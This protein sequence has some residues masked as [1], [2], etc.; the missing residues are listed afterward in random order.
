[1]VAPVTSSPSTGWQCHTRCQLPKT[2]ALD[3]CVQRVRSSTRLPNVVVPLRPNIGT[4]ARAIHPAWSGETGDRIVNDLDQ[5]YVELLERGFLVM[6]E[7][8]DTGDRVWLEAEMEMLHNIPSL[9]SEPKAKR[10]IYY[11]ACE[12]TAYRDWVSRNAHGIASS[13]MKTYYE[14]VWLSMEPL[15]SRLIEEQVLGEIA[16]D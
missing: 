2:Y 16:S 3:E 9:V 7:A 13:R 14:P 8:F 1:M 12:R 10:H 6:R 5:L 11:W 15:M 4:P